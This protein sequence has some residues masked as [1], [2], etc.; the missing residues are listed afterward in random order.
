VVAAAQI[1]DEGVPGGDDPRGAMGFQAAPQPEP[2]LHPT[3]IG[4]DQV[5]G[6][7]LGGVQRGAD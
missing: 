4:F 5:T 6:V 3:M 2:G 1:L 7:P